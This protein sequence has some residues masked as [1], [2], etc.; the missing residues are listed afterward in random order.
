M[1]FLFSKEEQDVDQDLILHSK[2]SKTDGLY[3]SMVKIF[4]ATIKKFEADSI[5]FKVKP[6]DI[7]LL[8]K[9]ITT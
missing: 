3:E 8:Q 5:W 4:W 6:I 7:P 9:N 1:L 2:V